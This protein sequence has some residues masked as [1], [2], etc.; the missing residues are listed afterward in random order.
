MADEL[1]IQCPNC[2]T[3]YTAD[4]CGIPRPDK[5]QQT[6][7]TVV[8][9]VCRT[10]FDT[11]FTPVVDAVENYSPNWFARNIMRRKATFDLVESVSVA[12]KSRG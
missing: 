4:R 11:V 8:C 1:R 5:A 6:I 7:A 3:S 12:V 10:Q 2:A 9:M